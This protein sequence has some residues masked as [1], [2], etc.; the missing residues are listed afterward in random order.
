LPDIGTRSIWPQFHEW[1]EKGIFSRI[2]FFFAKKMLAKTSCQNEDVALLIAT[3]L[4]IT[5][6]GHVCLKF[7]HQQLM[8]PLNGLSQDQEV[9]IELEKRM[10]NALELFPDEL[11]EKGE[12]VEKNPHLIIK[13]FC[14]FNN[15]LYLQK[16]WLYETRC[17]EHVQRL[18][19]ALPKYILQT[20][21]NV[22]DLNLE[23]KEAVLSALSHSLTLITGGP[24]TGKTYT[25]AKIVKAFLEQRP[26]SSIILAAPTGKAASHL[27]SQ[28]R[29]LIPGAASFTC[30]TLHALLQIRKEE[31]FAKESTPLF[32][33]LILIDECSMID[34]RLFSHFLSSIQKG[35]RVVLMGDVHQLSA[36]ESGHLFADLIAASL[37]GKSIPCTILKR[38]LRSNETEILQLADR[39]KNGD[40]KAV[41]DQLS[42]NQATSVRRLNLN[43]Q[44][45]GIAKGH[46]RLFEWIKKEFKFLS[47]ENVEPQECL[48]M[49]DRYRILSCMRKGPFG[50]DA[51]NEMIAKKCLAEIREDD[52]F[53]V[54]ILITRNDERLG[55]SNGTIGILKKKR[56]KMQEDLLDAE[57]LSYFHDPTQEGM[58]RAI[59]FA[60]LPPFEYAYCSSVHKSQGSEYDKVLLI[61][62]SGSE[63]FGRQ[64][65]YTGVTRAKH[66]IEIEAED[67]VLEKAIQTVSYKSSGFVDRTRDCV[68]VHS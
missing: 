2:S 32:G 50:V 20:A 11:I 22:D 45:N 34:L 53:Y 63:V 12:E 56:K 55:L 37:A 6:L 9:L 16:Y 41:I 59:P 18:T 36:I 30:S 46:A 21:P 48:A 47:K 7:D 49:L 42:Q 24:G 14:F 39:I 4:E 66:C 5:R 28:I 29:K 62:P 58:L 52:V 13:P 26:G 19:S 35:T 27:E 57:I 31:D 33:D 8:P 10:L 38:S 25:A 51:L 3:L 54:P 17:V 40:A 44:K 65:L 68:L 15:R 60:L 61:V 64:I 43:L 1:V 67:A 23:Q